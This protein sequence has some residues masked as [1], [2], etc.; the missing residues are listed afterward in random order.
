MIEICIYAVPKYN[1][2]SKFGKATC[3]L[4]WAMYTP[5][6]VCSH[7]GFLLFDLH[8]KMTPDLK[9]LRKRLQPIFTGFEPY[10]AAES[11]HEVFLSSSISRY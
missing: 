2:Y 5:A 8:N 4:F 10:L 6:R 9:G 1:G 3:R 7:L 11:I